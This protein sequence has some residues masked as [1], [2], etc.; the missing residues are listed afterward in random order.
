VIE[1]LPGGQQVGGRD[2]DPVESFLMEV[3]GSIFGQN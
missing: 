3:L 2:P 1:Y